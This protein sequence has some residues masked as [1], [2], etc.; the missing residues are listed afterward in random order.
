MKVSSS[1]VPPR[2]IALDIEVDQERLDKAVDQAYRRFAGQ[3]NVP[4][5]RKG[6]APRTM[7]ERIVGPDRIMEEALE[8]LLPD[9]VGEAIEQEHVEAFGRPRVESVEMD[10]LRLRAMVPLPPHV[11]LGKY[12]EVHVEPEQ[13]E[14]KPEQIDEVVERLRE[15]HAQWVPVE[16][17]VQT[18]DRVSIDLKAETTDP[19]RVLVD[20]KDAEYVV[21]AAG[22]EPAPGFA[23]QLV[24]MQ[25]DGTKEFDLTLP[26]DQRDTEVAGKTAHFSVAVHWV[27]QKELPEVDDAFAEQVGPYETPA[28]MHEAIE[29]ELRTREEQR[30][31]DETDAAAL[32]KLVEISQVKYPPQMVE[33]QADHL[34]QHLAQ[35]LERQGIRFE[36]YVRIT[37]KTQEEMR[38]EMEGDAEVQIRRALALEAFADAE[39]VPTDEEVGTEGNGRSREQRALRRLVSLATGVSEEDV[40]AA[41]ND[42]SADAVSD[43]DTQDAGREA[44]SEVREGESN[45]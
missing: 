11:E 17:E 13:V 28:A 2:Q 9:V 15:S 22:P 4:G 16:R 5:F 25:A 1:E 35:S 42:A 33:N 36:Q 29:S 21:D 31:R 27:K 39:K 19:E 44:S 7:V 37:G 41:R 30:V 23:E 24:G 43:T 3:V 26:E 12:D 40:D 34:L 38:K 14:I 6:K 32:D 8:H 10:P 18:G 45:T 20:T